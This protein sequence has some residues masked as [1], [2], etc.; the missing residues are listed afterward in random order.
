MALPEITINLNSRTIAA[1]RTFAIISHPDAGKTTL[2]KAIVVW[3]RHSPGGSVRARATSVVPDSDW[4]GDGTRAR[5][6]NHLHR[7]AIPLSGAVIIRAGYP[8]QRRLLR[9]I[10]TAP[11]RHRIALYMVLDAAKA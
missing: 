10:P 2:P 11:C 5:D 3:Q 8:R 1:R 4:N 6:L 9:K 7:A